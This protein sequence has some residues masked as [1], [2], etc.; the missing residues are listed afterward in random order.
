MF[1]SLEH[2]RGVNHG[3]LIFE[4]KDR[5]IM[6]PAPRRTLHL[7]V[8]SLADSVEDQYKMLSVR[9]WREAADPA[10]RLSFLIGVAH[11]E[12]TSFTIEIRGFMSAEPKA[13]HGRLRPGNNGHVMC[14]PPRWGRVRG[15]RP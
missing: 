6:A 8:L 4:A 15:A 3:E 12:A 9:C 14:G 10:C 2:Q 5:V 11:A 13:E 7:S 1:G